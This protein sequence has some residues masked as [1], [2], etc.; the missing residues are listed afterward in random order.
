MMDRRPTT[1]PREDEGDADGAIALRLTQS[2]LGPEIVAASS[3]MPF[4]IHATAL[5]SLIV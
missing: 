3:L 2:L 1:P 5:K 4:Q